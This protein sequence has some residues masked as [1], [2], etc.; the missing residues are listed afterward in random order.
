MLLCPVRNEYKTKFNF[1]IAESKLIERTINDEVI[2]V[3]SEMDE[4]LLSF[5]VNYHSPTSKRNKLRTSFDNGI[6]NTIWYEYQDI[7]LDDQKNYYKNNENNNNNNN[8]NFFLNGILQVV[9]VDDAL[10]DRKFLTKIVKTQNKL[11][12]IY[13]AANG[14]EVTNLFDNYLSRSCNENMVIFMDINM[15]SKNGFEATKEIRETQKE[16][17]P[18]II[19][20]SSIDTPEFK[21]KCI[22]SGMNSF[23]SKPFTVKK[24]QNLFQEIKIESK[25]EKTVTYHRDHGTKNVLNGEVLI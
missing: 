3:V 24:L 20:M 12:N 23:V 15:P 17:H 5:D 9:I 8:S 21:N 14:V 22:A 6:Y 13:T 2:P 18:I 1:D 16:I 10:V 19:G 4:V 25:E 7:S 11:I